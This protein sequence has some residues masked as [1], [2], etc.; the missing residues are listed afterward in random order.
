MQMDGCADREANMMNL[1]V[2]FFCNCLENLTRGVV[3][4]RSASH[5]PISRTCTASKF[6]K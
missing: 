1:M 5:D 6:V 4:S 2:F 3:F